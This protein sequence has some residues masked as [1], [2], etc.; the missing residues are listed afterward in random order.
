MFFPC[1]E[2]GK[3]L[4]RVGLSDIKLL[5][6]KIVNI[7][8]Q[9]GMPDVK[10]NYRRTESH[11]RLQVDEDGWAY[12]YKKG[13]KDND[14]EKAFQLNKAT[15]QGNLIYS[16]EDEG[17]QEAQ[18]EVLFKHYMDYT[19]AFY[20]TKMYDTIQDLIGCVELELSK[21][22]MKLINIVK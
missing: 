22:A 13:K 12:L 9:Y 20:L 17:Y 8:H 10:D 1:A 4:E 5:N 11:G 7:R 3:M 14:Y 19:N 16:I 2:D 18:K 15:T 21:N 6:N